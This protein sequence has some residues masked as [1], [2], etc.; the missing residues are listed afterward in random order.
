MPLVLTLTALVVLVALLI[1]WGILVRSTVAAAFY[2]ADTIRATRGLVAD[3][4]K[5]QLDE[6]TGVR[7]YAAARR[8]VLLQPYHEA[9]SRLPEFLHRVISAVDRLRMPEAS[10]ALRDASETNKRWLDTVA[11]PIVGSRRTNTPARE[12]RGKRLVDRFRND[13]HL[14]DI[15]LSRR[16]TAINADTQRAIGRVDLFS[17]AAVAAIAVVAAVFSVQ[18]YR[19]GIRLE[20]EY[21]KAEEEK[22]RSGGLR[23]AYL[24]EKRIADTLTGAFAQRPLPQVPTLRLSSIYAPAAEE[25]MV[26]G[27]WYDAFELPGNRVLFAIGDAAGHGI[28]AAVAMNRARQAIVFSGLVD[29]D[30]GLLLERANADLLGNG[31][32]IV[33]AVVG[34]VDVRYCEVRYAAAGHP[35]PLLVDPGRPARLLECGSIPLALVADA[36]YK[37]HRIQTV[38]GAMLVLYTDGLIE[39][40]RDIVEGEAMLLKAA[41]RAI[42]EDTDN[43]AAAIRTRIFGMRSTNDDVAILTIRFAETANIGAVVSSA[44]GQTSSVADSPTDEAAPGP[45]ILFV[46]GAV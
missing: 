16:E 23:A 38:P 31:S 28:E 45:Q 26:G 25:R 43:P 29:S 34:F 18:Q 12:L 30:P 6:E 22:R 14:A 2:S 36:Q 10:A 35:P 7:G 13:L 40:S 42:R 21:Q 27:D 9:R 5:Q 24:A 19:L 8:P 37:T 20:Q 4:M 11:F 46:S 17:L 15:T 32:P 3:L 33:T 41:E 44:A 39:H 1:V